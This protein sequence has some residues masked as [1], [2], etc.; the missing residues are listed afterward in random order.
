MFKRELQRV[1][2][3]RSHRKRTTPSYSTFLFSEPSGLTGAGSI[4]SIGGNYYDF[5]YSESEEEADFRAFEKDW[6]AV[7]DDMRSSFDRITKK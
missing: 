4:L 7:Y 1:S 2:S 5:N 3:V 6:E